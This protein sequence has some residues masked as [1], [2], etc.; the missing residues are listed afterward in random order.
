MPS[1]PRGQPP[2]KCHNIIGLQNS[3]SLST[4]LSVTSF[5]EGNQAVT[6]EDDALIARSQESDQFPLCNKKDEASNEAEDLGEE[7]NVED[8]AESEWDALDDQDFAER[9]AKMA[10]AD[11][12]NDMD[13]IP[14]RLHGKKGKT[15]LMCIFKYQSRINSHNPHQNVQKHTKEALM[16]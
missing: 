13:W 15:Y 11:D 7:T 10:M 1:K 16:S 3:S 6:K 8:Y 12:L 4:I 14:A 9:L 5:S 2:K